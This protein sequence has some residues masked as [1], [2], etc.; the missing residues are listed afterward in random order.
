MRDAPEFRAEMN[1]S[2]QALLEKINAE[3]D[4]HERLSFLTVVKD[5]WTVDNGFLTPTL[6][7]KRN[8]VENTYGPHLDGWYAAKQPVI[9]Q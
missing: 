5:G 4:P 3:V 8:I 9:W 7:I 2:F 1:G 6:K